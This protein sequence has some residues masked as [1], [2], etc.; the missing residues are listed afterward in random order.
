MLSYIFRDFHKELNLESKSGP[1][2]VLIAGTSGSGKTT[3]ARE[4]SEL[5][6]LDTLILPL[7]NYEKQGLDC[8][9][10]PD[11]Y[12]N[13]ENPITRNFELLYQN[14]SDLSRGRTTA[15]PDELTF[16]VT[17]PGDCIH[18]ESKEVTVPELI[19]VEGHLL[20]SDARIRA[21][22]SLA[23]FLHNRD[24]NQR[25]QRRQHTARD[26]YYDTKYFYPGETTFVL[27]TEQFADYSIDTHG[28]MPRT[29][30]GSIYRTIKNIKENNI[31]K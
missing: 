24:T 13:W 30:A 28:I 20:L 8:Q 12:I 4:I 2:I 27:P 21:M 29:L 18:V 9:V 22:A 23:V 25:I 14:L 3:V 26:V 10:E 6:E 11:G 7:D 1:P 17:K 16:R 31:A 15:I 19:I 5:T